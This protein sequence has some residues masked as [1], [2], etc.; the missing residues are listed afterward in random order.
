VIRKRRVPVSI[1][2]R[3]R[4]RLHPAAIAAGN[5]RGLC[6]DA[7]QSNRDALGAEALDAALQQQVYELARA[8]RQDRAAG[9]VGGLLAAL[10]RSIERDR[11]PY[12]SGPAGI[13]RHVRNAREDASALAEL[14]R[15][16][17][18]VADVVADGLELR[19][20]DSDAAHALD[21]YLARLRTRG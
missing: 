16:L 5:E 12:T 1:W 20:E 2:R 17:A 7:Y 4:S 14:L 3:L 18:E 10:R 19:A 6:L 9:S 13:A 21:E 15:N 8:L 11:R